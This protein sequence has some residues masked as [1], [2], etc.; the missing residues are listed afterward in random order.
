MYLTNVDGRR[1]FFSLLLLLFFI[2][3]FLTFSFL[4]GPIFFHSLVSGKKSHKKQTKGTDQEA[5]GWESLETLFEFP[6]NFLLSFVLPAPTGQKIIAY[7]KAS[8]C[9]SLPLNWG[10]TFVKYFLI[11]IY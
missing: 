7:S 2:I 6:E 9:R 1:F 11:I 8:L 10:M 3:L 4:W 5:A